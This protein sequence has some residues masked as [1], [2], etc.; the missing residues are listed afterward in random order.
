MRLTPQAF[1]SSPAIMPRRNVTQRRRDVFDQVLKSANCS[2]LDCLRHA[3]PKTLKAANKHVLVDLP[4]ESGGATFGPGIGLGPF[5][6]GGYLPDAMTVLF[7][8]GRFNQQVKSVISGNMAAEGLGLTSE[9]EKRS[10]FT[11]LVRRLVPGASETTIRR[12]RALYPYPD[13][14]YQ[15]VANDWTTDVAFGCNA[16]AIAQAYANITRRYVFSVPPATHGL[17]L[18]CMSEY[19]SIGPR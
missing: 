19:A 17:D 2:S 5:P 15:Q 6:D 11:Q 12:I 9:V 4:G 1:I 13:T 18:N 14:Q 10:E 16:Q 7:M 8:K 3:S